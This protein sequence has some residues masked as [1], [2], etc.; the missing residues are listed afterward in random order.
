MKC[1]IRFE[2]C[3]RFSSHFWRLS[4]DRNCKCGLLKANLHWGVARSSRARCLVCFV[5]SGNSAL[6]HGSAQKLLDAIKQR[7]VRRYSGNSSVEI[8]RKSVLFNF[9]SEIWRGNLSLAKTLQKTL[10]LIMPTASLL[11]RCANITVP[12]KVTENLFNEY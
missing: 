10:V 2:S 5:A 1:E 8:G 6:V 7:I 12:W 4:L 3:C 9:R 11:H